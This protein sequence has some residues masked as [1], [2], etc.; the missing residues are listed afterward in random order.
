MRALEAQTFSDFE[1]TVVDNTIRVAA[2]RMPNGCDLVCPP[3]CR[4]DEHVCLTPPLAEG[5]YIVVV[6]GLAIELDLGRPI[7]PSEARLL[8]EGLYANGLLVFRG[9]KLDL[10]RQIEIMSVFGK[11]IGLAVV[12]LLLRRRQRLGLA[13][14]APA[15]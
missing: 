10:D 7:G 11:M 1:V 6:E 2:T 5:S 14:S 9:Q 4:F 8:R 12:M 3:V 13:S 15:A